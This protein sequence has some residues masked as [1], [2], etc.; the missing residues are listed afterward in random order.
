MYKDWSDGSALRKVTKTT[1]YKAILFI[2]LT[3]LISPII[4]Y[5]A[6]IKL[7]LINPEF[8]LSNTVSH[9]LILSTGFFFHSLY[10]FL[11]P[12]YFYNKLSKW[13]LL[14]QFTCTLLYL[15]ILKFI[16]LYASNEILMLLKS[17]L[18]IFMTL[19]TFFG[20]IKLTRNHVKP[21]SV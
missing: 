7:N 1:I 8:I 5:F 4:I 18:L 6:L 16:P 17:S 21:I 3:Q 13:L 2:F 19:F 15:F 10:H 14:I 9:I 11:N 12:Y 20:L